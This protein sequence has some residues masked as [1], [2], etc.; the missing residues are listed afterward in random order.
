V[1]MFLLAVFLGHVDVLAANWPGAV[2][3]A[4]VYLLIGNRIFIRTTD[5][6]YNVA[7]TLFIAIYGIAVL[8]KTLPIFPA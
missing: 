6:T 3:S 7:L 2:V 5:Q 8:L 1:Q 4:S